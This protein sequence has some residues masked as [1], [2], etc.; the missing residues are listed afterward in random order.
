MYH[1]ESLR[2]PA[3]IISACPLHARGGDVRPGRGCGLTGFWARLLG[4][5]WITALGVELVAEGADGELA[6]T[7]ESGIQLLSKVTAGMA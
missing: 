2:F 7:G 6:V 5:A 4:V 3:L 1:V